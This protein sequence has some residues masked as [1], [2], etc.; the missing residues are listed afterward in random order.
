MSNQ[1]NLGG[2]P[3]TLNAGFVLPSGLVDATD[4]LASIT[5]MTAADDLNSQEPKEGKEEDTDEE[6][7]KKSKKRK[8]G[9]KGNSEISDARRESHKIIEQKRRQKINEK[10]NELRE[11]LNYPDGSQNKA[12][13]LQAAVES[14]KNLKV[15]CSKLL[16]HHRQLQEEYMHLL[17]E[18]DRLRKL[19]MTGRPNLPQAGSTNGTPSENGNSVMQSGKDS[20]MQNDLNKNVQNQT[21]KASNFGQPD[22]IRLPPNTDPV[23]LG[24]DIENQISVPMLSQF[25][26][27]S[28]SNYAPS[29]NQQNPLSSMSSTPNA[30]STPHMGLTTPSLLSQ[31][32]ELTSSVPTSTSSETP[33]NSSNINET[34]PGSSINRILYDQHPR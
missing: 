29:M 5:S 27:Y 15:V 16:A 23:F 24:Y 3:K 30:S 28:R 18:N 11:I 14:I 1:Q 25:H 32:Y 2:A 10:I 21:P 22:L 6:D 31:M 8:K 4:V 17:G 20:G 13:V 7:G 26:T 9:P 33:T 19:A 34:E 12:V